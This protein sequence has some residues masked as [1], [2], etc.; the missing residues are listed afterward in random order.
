MTASDMTQ[1]ET[2][3]EDL[4]EEMAETTKEIIR[5][6]AKRIDLAKKIGQ[7]KSRES[8][9]IDNEKVED[10]LLKDILLESKQLGLDQRLATKMLGMLVLESKK[11]Q[12]MQRSDQQIF[13]LIEEAK[14]VEHAG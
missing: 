6:S 9:P 13:H 11:V 10:A 14:I 1:K 3:L 4:R 5:L 8:L 7:V 2:E 12:R